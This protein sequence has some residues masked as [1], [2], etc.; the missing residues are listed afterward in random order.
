MCGPSSRR[1][2]S[3]AARWG[4]TSSRFSQQYPATYGTSPSATL[5]DGAEPLPQPSRRP[6]EACWTAVA[7]HRTAVEATTATRRQLLAMVNTAPEEPRTPPS[8]A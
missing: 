8:A 5:R 1:R 7:V 2:T 3:I 4:F 6:S